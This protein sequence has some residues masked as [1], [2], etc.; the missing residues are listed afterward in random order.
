MKKEPIRGMKQENKDGTQELCSV[1]N[2][3][4]IRVSITP[5]TLSRYVGLNYT[6][7]Q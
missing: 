6:A 2:S 3:L 1:H 4:G 5:Q 7:E